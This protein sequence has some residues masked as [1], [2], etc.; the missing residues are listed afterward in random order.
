[1]PAGLLRAAQYFLASTC[2][3]L[4]L[5]NA[6]SYIF[7]TSFFSSGEKSGRSKITIDKSVVLESQK[8]QPGS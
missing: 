5:I 3:K 6:E 1:M 8:R 4:S 7:E 2:L